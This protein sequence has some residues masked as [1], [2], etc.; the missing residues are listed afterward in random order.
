MQGAGGEPRIWKL[1][2]TA[3]VG[4]RGP[5]GA[6]PLEGLVAGRLCFLREVRSPLEPEGVP[7]RHTPSPVVVIVALSGLLVGACSS[8]SSPIGSESG[9]GGAVISNGAS[10]GARGSGGAGS[11]GRTGLGGG[12]AP[13]G[14]GGTS[15]AFPSTGSAP[16]SAVAGTGGRTVGVSGRAGA[17]NTVGAT[18]EPPRSTSAVREWLA[19]VWL[20]PAWRTRAPRSSARPCPTR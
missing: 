9:S 1:D 12:G 5:P 20:A 11:G 18:G 8:S 7:M 16:G 2:P 17:A 6:T 3:R 19:A 14:S 10:S 13:S 4:L 15:G